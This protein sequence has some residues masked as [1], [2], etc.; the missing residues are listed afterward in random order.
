M[1]RVSISNDRR[2]S[3]PTTTNKQPRKKYL[4]AFLVP[5]HHCSKTDFQYFQYFFNSLHLHRLPGPR[6]S[7]PLLPFY[8]DWSPASSHSPTRKS[9]LIY[10]SCLIRFSLSRS[11]ELERDFEYRIQPCGK[12]SR[13]ILHSRKEKKNIEFRGCKNIAALLVGKP[14]SS[15]TTIPNLEELSPHFLSLA[16]S[17]RRAKHQSCT[18]CT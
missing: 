14:I 10:V 15:H 7:T 9:D 17:A 8:P 12:A 11:D 1:Y 13:V 6:H 3:R 2:F 4:G 5:D 18:Y 16:Q